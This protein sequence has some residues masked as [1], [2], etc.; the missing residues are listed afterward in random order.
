[1]VL[2]LGSAVLTVYAAELYYSLIS[3]V[4][5]VDPRGTQM[6]VWVASYSFVHKWMVVHVLYVLVC[7]HIKG[8]EQIT[9][10]LR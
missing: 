5:L 10:A 8:R 4:W 1:M 7:R 9:I 6:L 2:T 3:C